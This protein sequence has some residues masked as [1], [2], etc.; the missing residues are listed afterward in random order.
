MLQRYYVQYLSGYD[1][2]AL[3]QVLQPLQ[4]LS[5]DDSVILSSLCNTIGG[6]SIKQGIIIFKD[7]A[8]LIQKC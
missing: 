2:V 5:E 4:T 8:D 3:N 7:H 1:A 6:L